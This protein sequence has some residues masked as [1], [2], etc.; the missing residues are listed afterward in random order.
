MKLKLRS[1][2]AFEMA[3]LQSGLRRGEHMAP[4]R[5][6]LVGLPSLVYIPTICKNA[7]ARAE[8]SRFCLVVVGEIE[9]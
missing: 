1:G 2:P 8:S 4:G 6:C 9:D 7:D 5:F 3:G